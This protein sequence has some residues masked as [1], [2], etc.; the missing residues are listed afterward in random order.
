MAFQDAKSPGVN[1][2]VYGA[3]FVF[4]GTP[5]VSYKFNPRDLGLETTSQAIDGD[6]RTGDITPVEVVSPAIAPVFRH[7][8]DEAFE[9]QAVTLFYNLLGTQT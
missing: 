4:T 5:D 1:K 7:S 3:D 6:T 9:M 8:L 2:Q